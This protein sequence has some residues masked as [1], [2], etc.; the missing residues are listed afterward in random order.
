MRI[1][2]ILPLSFCFGV[3]CAYFLPSLPEKNSLLLIVLPLLLSVKLRWFIYPSVFLCGCAWLIFIGHTKL[4]T[5]LPESL[6]KQT[7][8][9][10]GYVNY[11]PVNQADKIKFRLQIR[12][13]TMHQLSKIDC[14]E[15]DDKKIANIKLVELSW[16]QPT[17]FPKAGEYWY[18]KAKLRRPRSFENPGGFDYAG[19]LYILGVDATGYIKEAIHDLENTDYFFSI[20]VLREK[21]REKLVEKTKLHDNQA[22]LFALM[23]GD[24]SM[25]SPEIWSLFKKTGTNHLMAISGLHIGMI[26]GSMFL[27]VQVLGRFISI[28]NYWPRQKIAAVMCLIVALLYSGL[29][30]FSLPTLR[31]LIMLSVVLAGVI[32]SRKIRLGWTFIFALTLML[33]INPLS[34]GSVSFWL[35]FS[36][37]GVLVF[38]FQTSQRSLLRNFFTAQIVIFLG[39]FPILLLTFNQAPLIS[40]IANSIAVPVVSFVVVP[41]DFLG[42]LLLF[43][44]DPAGEFLLVLSDRIM[45]FLLILL[46]KMA[47]IDFSL[48][49]KDLNQITVW[50]GLFVMLC[51]GVKFKIFNK[52]F[53]VIVLGLIFLIPKPEKVS[54]GE[55]KL[56]LLDVG[57][58]LSV[59][60]QTNHHVLVFDVGARFG[61][62][63]FGKIV[64][65]PFLKRQGIDHVDRLVISHA[66]NDHTGGLQSVLEEISIASIYVGENLDYIDGNRQQQC[67][68]GLHW[69]WDNVRFSFIH[70]DRVYSK[71]NNNSCVLKIQTDHL[72]VLIPGDIEKL[73]EQ[74]LIDYDDKLLKADI[75]IAPHHGSL[76]SSTWQFIR[77]VA[78]DYVWISAGYLNQFGH[79]H[80]KILKRYEQL[81]VKVLN[82]AFTGAITVE[83]RSF[84]DKKVLALHREKT[85]RFWD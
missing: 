20:H 41:L 25:F 77:K 33:I 80:K 21:I 52:L 30:G 26:S 75:L 60:V 54:R 47:S 56:S 46:T 8:W 81:N 83:S 1:T 45:S 37:V 38:F 70:P 69:A 31:A 84:Y 6:D 72:T 24:R 62:L 55:F 2:F 53:A 71:A 79:P 57:Q 14:E 18:I 39:L 23:L 34:I 74:H 12:C 61:G 48:S 4:E 22:I 9:L 51:T 7:V 59:I 66:D 3:F 13:I 5:K 32:M 85:Q 50:L 58:G 65:I 16:Y 63:D 42:C 29:A 82:T 19:W 35:S 36:A 10:Q 49:V 67:Q 76:T 64:V 43:V 15:K 27:L 78:P 44:F 68:Q 73:V 28:L 11:L 17:D 40:P